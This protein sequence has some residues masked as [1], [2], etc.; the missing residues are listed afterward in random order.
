NSKRSL[1]GYI[2]NNF[3]YNNFSF[4]Q[5]YRH[6]DVKIKG[7]KFNDS[8]EFVPFDSTLTEKALELSGTYKYRDT[9]LVFLSFS[10]SFRTPN[11]D[12]TNAS[13]WYG[14]IEAQRTKNYEIGI[15]ENIGKISISASTFIS[16]TENEI[17]FRDTPHGNQN[18]D[19]TNKRKGTDLSLDLYLDKW[20]FKGSYSYIEHGA[21]SGAYKGKNIPGVP[22]NRFALGTVFQP[23]NKIKINLDMNYNGSSYFP[24]DDMNKY[25]KI[26][27]YITVDGK[28]SYNIFENLQIF[29][30]INNIFDEQYFDYAQYSE[31]ELMPPS[32][33]FPDGLIMTDYRIYPANGRNYYSGFKYSF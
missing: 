33:Y 14:D 31:L 29:A 13:N 30:G 8:Y 16:Y 17:F 15:K 1:G 7:I 25:T 27:S 9:G 24:T 11:T 22:N 4:S 3:N 20:I 28:I 2:L 23:N 5:G 6:Q 26:G 21:K 18:S 12:D 19:G 32:S 10:Q